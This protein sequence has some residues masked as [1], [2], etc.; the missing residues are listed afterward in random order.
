MGP[1]HMGLWE[2]QTNGRTQRNVM[3]GRGVRGDERG[4]GEHVFISCQTSNREREGKAETG[5][6][7]SQRGPDLVVG[8]CPAGVFPV[9]DDELMKNF[10]M[11]HPYKLSHQVV[12]EQLLHYF[13]NTWLRLK[14]KLKLNAS[15]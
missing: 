15:N 4:G 14:L 12:E 2:R 7:L 11:Q 5:R 9:W 13:D 10:S 1:G 6:G 8:C 3:R